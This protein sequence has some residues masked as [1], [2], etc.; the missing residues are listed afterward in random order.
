MHTL[1]VSLQHA[2]GIFNCK[3]RF[4]CSCLFAGGVG[5]GGA[6]AAV[7]DS[8]VLMS[9]FLFYAAIILRISQL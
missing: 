9:R 2:F 7:T 6:A 8:M 4:Y 5:G 1:L 3:A